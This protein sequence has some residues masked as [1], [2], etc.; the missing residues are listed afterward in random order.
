MGLAKDYTDR[1]DCLKITKALK[2]LIKSEEEK[3]NK[4]AQATEE[5]HAY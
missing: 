3:L 1:M 5:G 4:E 2:I